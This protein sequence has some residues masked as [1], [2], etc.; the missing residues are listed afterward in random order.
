MR[1]GTVTEEYETNINKLDESTTNAVRIRVLYL[2]LRLF[3]FFPR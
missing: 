1:D 2:T 3:V